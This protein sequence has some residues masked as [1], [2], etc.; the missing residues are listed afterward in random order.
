MSFINNI[1]NNN[2]NNDNNNNNQSLTHAIHRK[3]IDYEIKNKK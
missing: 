1:I 2:N 3:A